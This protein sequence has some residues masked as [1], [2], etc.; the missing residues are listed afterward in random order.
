VSA[1]AKAERRHWRLVEQAID[2]APS[3]CACFG[4]CE[5]K[6]LVPTEAGCAY[7]KACDHIMG[8][9]IVK[10]LH[11]FHHGPKVSATFRRS[12]PS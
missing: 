10:G 6:D 2:S 12:V 7:C 4:K 1:R 3:N 5:P 11:A 9:Q 8:K